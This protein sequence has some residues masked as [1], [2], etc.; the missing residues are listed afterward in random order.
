MSSKPR[1]PLVDACVV[2]HADSTLST[3]PNFRFRLLLGG[4]RSLSISLKLV[5]I[6]FL[7]SEGTATTLL[8]IL[9]KSLICGYRKGAFGEVVVVAANFLVLEAGAMNQVVLL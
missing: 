4:T 7:L 3:A 2:P 8:E 9:P 6:A 1:A 5:E